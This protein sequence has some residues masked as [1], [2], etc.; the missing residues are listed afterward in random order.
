MNIL[1]T[2]ILNDKLPY[3]V[4]RDI[5]RLSTICSL[6]GQDESQSFFDKIHNSCSVKVEPY[7]PVID[8]FQ[9]VLNLAGKGASVDT[10]NPLALVSHQPMVTSLYYNFDRHRA[11]LVLT[12]NQLLVKIEDDVS[13]ILNIEVTSLSCQFQNLLE[14]SNISKSLKSTAKKLVYYFI[15]QLIE[16]AGGY[17]DNLLQSSFKLIPIYRK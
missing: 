2:L 16:N 13:E 7:E 15:N 14:Q 5:N 17:Y 4:F 1:E 3:S 6:F 9:R 10:S 8:N 12:Q 11:S